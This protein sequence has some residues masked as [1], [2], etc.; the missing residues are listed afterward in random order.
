M[1]TESDKAILA[2]IGIG[3]PPERIYGWRNSH[4]SLAKYSG[5]I[6]YQGHQYHI[7]VDEPGQP[8]VREDVLKREAREKA[9]WLKTDRKA[10]KLAAERAQGA[11]F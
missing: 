2:R 1:I 3:A 7:A 11:M 9:E 5:S 4:F 6:K 8:L 10:E